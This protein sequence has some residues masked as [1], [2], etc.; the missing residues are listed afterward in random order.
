[1]TTREEAQALLSLARSTIAEALGAPR[2]SV[3]R[4]ALLETP[5]GCS[6]TPTSSAS[7]A[8]SIVTPVAMPPDGHFSAGRSAY[9]SPA[10]TASKAAFIPTSWPRVPVARLHAAITLGE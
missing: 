7:V 4:L 10:V 1:M 2:A 9:R 8:A 5:R 3:P 6:H